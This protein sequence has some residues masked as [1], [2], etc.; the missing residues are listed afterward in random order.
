MPGFLCRWKLINYIG[1]T[2]IRFLLDVASTELKKLKTTYDKVFAIT[3][4]IEDA[5]ASKSEA[6]VK[7]LVESGLMYAAASK[8]YIGKKFHEVDRQRVSVSCFNALIPKIRI[9]K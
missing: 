9:P 3:R 4:E 1:W 7:H 6:C 2:H 5:P 8:F